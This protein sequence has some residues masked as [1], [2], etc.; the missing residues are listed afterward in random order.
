MPEMET[1]VLGTGL[2]G[3]KMCK[4][5]VSCGYH[6]R[7]WNR[8][9]EKITQLAVLGVQPCATIQ[10]AI[11][12]AGVILLMLADA[13]AIKEVLL[14]EPA[15]RALLSGKTVLQMGTIGRYDGLY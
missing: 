3:A 10:D 7:A 1:A 6:V 14:E 8:T 15:T 12:G 11:R 9:S 13:R 5:L 2:M 4:R